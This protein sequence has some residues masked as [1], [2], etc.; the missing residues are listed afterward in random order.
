MESDYQ[1]PI[2]IGHPN[3]FSIRELASLVRELINPKLEFVYKE[4]PEDDPKQRK[5]SIQLAKDLL[6]W[7][8]KWCFEKT[9]EKTVTWY[10]SYYNDKENA[11]NYCIK[12][13]EDFLEV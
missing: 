1:N 6:D 10:K 2:N 4:L 5:P 9:V 11:L 3:A 13:V 8:P 12:D 7:E